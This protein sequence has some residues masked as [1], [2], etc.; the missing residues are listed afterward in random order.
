MKQVKITSAGIRRALRRYDYSASIAEY[1]WNGFD[2]E[3]SYVRIFAESNTLGGISKIK[4]IDNGSGI[5]DSTK[6]DPFLE[7]DKEIDPNTPRT[8]SNSHGKNGVGRLTFFTFAESATWETVYE[9]EGK[10]YKYNIRVDSNSLNHYSA[11]D[12]VE[13]LEKTGTTVIFSG[14]QTIVLDDFDTHIKEFLC[15]EFAWFL[16]LK[17]SNEFFIEINGKKINYDRILIDE[18]ETT[19]YKTEDCLFEVKFIRWSQNLR[20]EYSRYYF[21]NSQDKEVYTKTTTFNKKGDNFFH[22]VYVKSS[23]FNSADVRVY[24]NSPVFKN[25]KQ[26]KA[27]ANL[28]NFLENLLS[29]KRKK[30]LRTTSDNI[31]D[32]LEKN[33]AF[34]KFKK[35]TWEQSRKS[36]LEGFI[37]E[38]YQVEPKIFTNLNKEQKKVFV[39]FLNLIIDSGERDKLIEILGEIISIDPIELG[40]LA[41]SLKASKLSNIIRTV[42]LIED[43]YKA[44]EEMRNL[45]FN[46]DLK[47]N[48]PDHLQR[49]MEN[50]Y[51]I[52]GEQYHLITAAEPRFEEALR[53]YVY[54]LKGE[55][56]VVSIDHPDKN[57]EMD[58]FMV[59][60]LLNNDSI[61][62]VVVE[63]KHPRVNLGSKE[64]EQV[65]RY[66]GVI[67]EQDEF[68]APNMSWEFYLIGNGFDT[69]G[70]IERE[71]KNSKFHGEKSLVYSVDNYKIYVKTWSEIFAEF[72]LRH[73]FLN[74]KLKLERARLIMSEVSA[75]SIIANIPYSTAIQ[76]PQ[77]AISE[78]Q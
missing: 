65:K 70:Y 58:L 29:K 23:F 72:E 3:S 17:L 57:K 2:A 56:P 51:W 7:S 13:T 30:F 59:R 71:I 76:P 77:I 34:P 16:E 40:H 4:I 50:H 41:E 1:I 45:V 38:L 73:K 37:R 47:A 15:R 54:I 67:L 74:E 46:P 78:N 20:G 5:I 9:K 69:S 33:D 53:R 36:E 8:S 12:A 6:F 19:S 68:N 28:M 66:M 11:S 22:S 24:D 63:L 18:Q 25:I 10:N 35:D 32:A 61:N 39:H 64:L 49:F 75:D 42:K 55:R 60:Q 43:R 48:E 26:G 31:I 44:I 14:I 52:L 21:I 27:Y 62:N